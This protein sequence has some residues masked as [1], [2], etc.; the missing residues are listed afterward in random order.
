MNELINFDERKLELYTVDHTTNDN[1]LFVC[2][3]L[4][5]SGQFTKL[6]ALVDRAETFKDHPQ[7]LVY[8][9]ELLL[10]EMK[11]E[12]AKDIF[13][14]A[15]EYN[16]LETYTRV[17]LNR[18]EAECEIK[19]AQFDK[20]SFFLN[21][22][23]GLMEDEDIGRR[24]YYY[25]QFALAQLTRVQGRM[26]EAKET[27]LSLVNNLFGSNLVILQG[28]VYYE[29]G[30]VHRRLDN[31]EAA[32]LCFRESLNHLKG[33]PYRRLEPLNGLANI[34]LESERYDE[35]VKLY[36]EVIDGSRSLGN[37]RIFTKALIN[38][39]LLYNR[40]GFLEKAYDLGEQAINHLEAGE[41]KIE[42]CSA[43]VN[44]GTMAQ[45][46]GYYYKAK[47]YYQRCFTLA[48]SMSNPYYAAYSAINLA[49]VY[50]QQGFYLKAKQLF[51][52]AKKFSNQ[53]HDLNALV[54]SIAGL[55]L[56]Y[57][58]MRSYKKAKKTFEEAFIHFDSIPFS[59]DQANLLIYGLRILEKVGILTEDSAVVQMFPDN[60]N[61]IPRLQF[62][63]LIKEGILLRSG[64]R[65]EKAKDVF[66]KALTIENLTYEDYLICYQEL[67]ECFMI[68]KD[69]D[70]LEDVLKKWK[71]KAQ[72]KNLVGDLC[73][74]TL[75]QASISLLFYDFDEAECLVAQAL[76]TTNDF[77]LPLHEK[78]ALE[79]KSKIE[80]HRHSLSSADR[81]ISGEYKQTIRK[82]G[83][84][85]DK[86]RSYILYM[87]GLLSEMDEEEES[88]NLKLE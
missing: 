59:G 51:K 43:L 60:P 79:I 20:A 65:H 28:M 73:K 76:L 70:Q 39:G 72:E 44:V 18:L 2:E 3:L 15:L 31:F 49:D 55:S 82:S 25:C 56:I 48:K 12:E 46:L 47:K 62:Y 61:N 66:N 4:L 80:R 40:L 9:G 64:G 8:K 84:D 45:S 14:K 33:S 17:R 1:F 38:L 41:D 54:H 27:L 85:W 50:H 71:R 10:K 86:I 21:I 26:T 63:T 67:S 22:A 36:Q 57:F 24:E 53:S 42:L 87:A 69:I 7:L 19:L 13:R 68:L 29:L 32:E 5:T 88:I 37:K 83:E 35:A 34:Q 52:E 75:A 11:F 78:L 30:I 6:R 74:I 77:D 81:A 16:G 23:F 58:E